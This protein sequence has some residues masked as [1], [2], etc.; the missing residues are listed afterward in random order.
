MPNY[1]ILEMSSMSFRYHKGLN[2]SSKVFTGYNIA[3]ED[4]IRTKG[5]IEKKKSEKKLNL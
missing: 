3:I 1:N 4:K 5:T 2:L